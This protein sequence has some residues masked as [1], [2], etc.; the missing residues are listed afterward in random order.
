MDKIKIGVIGVGY[1]GRFHAQK[2]AALEDV[3]LIGV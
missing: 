1:L 2:Y 3:T